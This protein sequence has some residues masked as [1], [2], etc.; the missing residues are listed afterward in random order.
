MPKIHCPSCDELTNCSIMAEKNTFRCNDCDNTFVVEE[1]LTSY[2]LL[3]D[4]QK[5]RQSS[6]GQL[7]PH[8]ISA[9]TIMAALKKVNEEKND[10]KLIWPEGFETTMFYLV[11]KLVRMSTDPHHHDSCLDLKS[12]ADLWLQIIEETK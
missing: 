9:D 3:I 1:D 2:D 5:D 4:T 8:A 6:Y 10:G 11:T 7:L 12:Y